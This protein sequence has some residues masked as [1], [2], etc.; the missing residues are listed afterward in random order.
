MSCEDIFPLE[1]PNACQPTLDGRRAYGTCMQTCPERKCCHCQLEFHADVCI[2]NHVG[3]RSSFRNRTLSL[4]WNL[5]PPSMGH[6]YPV[7]IKRLCEG[8]QTEWQVLEKQFQD[9]RSPPF[10]LGSSLWNT[11]AHPTALQDLRQ[12]SRALTAARCDCC[13][14]LPLHG[15]MASSHILQVLLNWVGKSPIGNKSNVMSQF[16]SSVED[17]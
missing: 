15:Q 9:V 3:R 11:V 6:L 17:W 8:H 4:G 10:K 2:R 5:I 1:V 13:N 12:S 16:E 7:P 14:I